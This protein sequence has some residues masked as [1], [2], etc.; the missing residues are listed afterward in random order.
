VP[1]TITET[2]ADALK[3]PYAAIALKESEDFIVVA[4]YA[5][6]SSSS[7]ANGHA[8]RLPLIY[9]SETIGQLILA[10]RAPG[11]SFSQNDWHLLETI[12]RQAGI[13]AYNVRLTQDLQRSRERLVTTREEERRRLRRDLHDGLGPALAAMS[14]KLDA[15][16]NLVGHDPERA[17]NLITDL[18]TQIQTF[19]ADI[20][21]IAYDLRPP[22]LDE[23]GL[24]GALREHVTS[25]QG[26]ELCIT[27]EAPET[28][29]PL[30]A[31]VEVAAY[32]IVMEAIN[33]VHRHANA[34]HCTVRLLLCDEL[35]LEVNDDGYGIP[36]HVRVGVGM[37]SMRERAEELG[38]TC[39]FENH[40]GQG[41]RVLVQLPLMTHVRRL[42][43]E[44]WKTY[45][46]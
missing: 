33:N 36:E 20:R 17:R 10:P 18:K 19:L 31:A 6:A 38:G 21:R 11:E 25:S 2:V 34:Q 4:E 24:V 44:T 23:L 13:A 16:A 8:E 35:C 43:E 15:S 7:V 41:T 45:A 28:L 27:L 22:A 14:F 40:P 37:V 26:Q 46:S 30:A 29:P 1:P 5:R 39:V 42:E 32:R 12:A 9:Q 3:L